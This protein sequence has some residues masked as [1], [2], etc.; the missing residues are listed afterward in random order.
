MSHN[1]LI[2][3]NKNVLQTT[4]DT[5]LFLMSFSNLS[6]TIQIYEH[7]GGVRGTIN[8]HLVERR[9][10]AYSGKVGDPN[11][12]LAE[13]IRSG[14]ICAGMGNLDSKT[15]PITYVICGDL[16]KEKTED[17]IHNCINKITARN[18]DGDR[19][20]FIG[21]KNGEPERSMIEAFN[22]KWKNLFLHTRFYNR[23]AYSC[24]G[25]KINEKLLEQLFSQERTELDY[26]TSE[27]MF[28][29]LLP[30]GIENVIRTTVHGKPKQLSKSRSRIGLLPN[31]MQQE[32]I[33]H[34]TN[35]RLQ[36]NIHYFWYLRAI[37]AVIL[38]IIAI[39]AF[40]MTMLS[41]HAIFIT[42][43][44]VVTIQIGGALL[45]KTT[46]L[47]LGSISSAMTITSEIASGLLTLSLF[48]Q[49]PIAGE[50]N[51]NIPM[52][53]ERKRSQV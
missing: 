30:T 36:N 47:F 22:H 43:A 25:D 13:I 5:N 15:L 40:V 14:L 50:S 42:G 52:L 32:E 6:E 35:D 39:V 7:G 51:M 37:A 1:D 24:N 3:I 20:L 21:F 31:G 19:I 18:V 49:K 34:T 28:E 26:A 41:L 44:P 2:M 33:Q 11:K 29:D 4:L 16:D 46:P 23:K 9:K 8:S 10:N 12:E 53:N 48:A 45:L 38:A 17:F 27:S